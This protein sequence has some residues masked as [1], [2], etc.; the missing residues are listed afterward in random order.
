[1]AP[2]PVALLHNCHARSNGSDQT[3]GLMAR[4]ERER[5]FH[6]PVAVG[7]M[8]IGVAYPAGFGLD[9][10]LACSGRGNV[11]FYKLQ[12]FSELLDNR[13]VHLGVA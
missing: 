11:Q 6:W 12:R 5:R 1:M 2:D 13:R 4:N 7:R 8:Q 3:D 10:D 9:Q